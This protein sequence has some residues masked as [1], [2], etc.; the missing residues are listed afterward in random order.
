MPTASTMNDTQLAVAGVYSRA[1]LELARE[2]GAEDA[3]LEELAGLAGYLAGHPE[4]AD[5]FASP[6]VDAAARRETVEKTFR[7]R[8]SDLLVDGLQ[9]LNRKGRLDLLP[10][11]AEAYRRQ[12]RELK[13]IVDVQVRTAVP[14]S[15]AL[16]DRLAAAARRFT[17]REPHLVE[18]VQP[19]LLGGLVIQVGDQKI[20]ASI[21]SQLH[22]ISRRLDERGSQEIYRG[23]TLSGQSADQSAEPPAAPAP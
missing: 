13:G 10:A 23:G 12:H 4:V 1:L 17:G 15:P 16:R 14:L 2:T 5:F 8:A 6:L 18:E 21:A 7:G 9:V 3:L 22:E 20:D 19:G 11:V